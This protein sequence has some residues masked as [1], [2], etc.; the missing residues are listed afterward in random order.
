MIKT[1]TN[2]AKTIPF[3]FMS[4]MVVPYYLFYLNKKKLSEKEFDEILENLTKKS[5]QLGLLEIVKILIPQY[6]NIDPL[7]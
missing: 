7:N 1:L 5:E 3:V 2:L 4:Q 6:F